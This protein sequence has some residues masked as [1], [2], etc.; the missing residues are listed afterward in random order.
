M[1]TFKNVS[2]RIWDKPILKNINW[3]TES[4]QSWSIL[5]PNGAGKT[6]LANLILGE[7]PYCGAIKR[8]GNISNLGEIAHV[9]LEQQKNLVSREEKKDLYEEYSGI[10]EHFLTGREFMDP[11]GKK[12]KET[13][14]IAK[15][16]GLKSILENPMRYY[17]NGETR[18]TLIGK[19]L[20]SDPK[21]LILD[22]PFEGLDF[23][24][25]VWLKHTISSLIRKGLVIFLISNRVEDLVPEITHVLCL[26]SGKVFAKGDRAEVLTPAI[27]E[28]LYENKKSEEEEGKNPLIENEFQQIKSIKKK[29]NVDQDVVILMRNVNVRYGEKIVLENFNWTVRNGENWKIMGPNGAGKSTLLSLIT[30]DNL[31]VYSNEI[32]MFGNQRGTGE[33]IW[34]IKRRIGHVSSE[35]Q[36]QY[37]ESVSVLKVVLSGLFDTV[38]L[39]NPVTSKQKETALNW[40]KF[41]E[42][43]NLAKIDFTRL[44]YGQQRLVL[45]ARAL[46][47]SPA[48]LIL[49]EPCQGLDWTNRNRVLTLIDR[50]GHHGATQIIYVTHIPSDHLKCIHHELCFE[51][52]ASGVFLPV[53]S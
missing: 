49:D 53:F 14:K 20:L 46:V 16:L 3:T 13:L 11:Q 52:S 7:L 15:K 36:V 34:D 9:S 23:K 39:Y 31:Q 30:A 17:S 41:F 43:E 2:N 33:S 32:H 29:F 6:T 22:E 1:I 26:K 12:T 5:G 40:M 21:L 51:E 24:S 25:V 28:L 27:M 47:K 19:A 38:G 37:R 35:F 48:L 44:S 10:E 18:K 8:D 50:L 42:I 4:G 45:I